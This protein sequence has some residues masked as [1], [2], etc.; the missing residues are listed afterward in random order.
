MRC[1]PALRPMNPPNASSPLAG[2]TVVV[3]RPASS[4]AALVRRI[5]ASGGAPLSLP[6]LSLRAADAG[7]APL[8]APGRYDGWIFVSPAAVRFA[9]RAVPSLH[10]ANG[11]LVC[12]VGAGT[13]RAL[14]RRGVAAVAPDRRADSEGLLAMPE[15]AEMRGQ[16][17]ALV[18]APG[19]RDLIATTLRARGAEVEAIHVYE[20]VPPRWSARQLQALA[21]AASPLV[22]L[23]SSGEALSNL[24]ARLP[25]EAL[26]RLRRGTLVVSSERLADVARANAF[27]DVRVAASALPADLLAAAQKALAR[28]RL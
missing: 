6:G 17:V 26:A 27:G 2:A 15:L 25:D 21:R 5:R 13:R 3:T 9:F 4:A 18:G 24:V 19:G 16:R 14:A 10:I 20:R 23:L 28:H 12:G 7:R 8:R 22:T 11:T 1:P